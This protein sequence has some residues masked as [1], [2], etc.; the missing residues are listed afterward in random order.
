MLEEKERSMIHESE[1]C[2]WHPE[3]G[4]W[5]IESTPNR[6]YA[7]YARLELTVIIA[8]SVAVVIVSVLLV[9]TFL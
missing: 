6:P 8:I 9:F 5:M 7:N 2:T 3:F 4:A 1:G